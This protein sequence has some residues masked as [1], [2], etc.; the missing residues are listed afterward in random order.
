MNWEDRLSFNQDF[1]YATYQKG[2]DSV[3]IATARALCLSGLDILRINLIPLSEWKCCYRMLLPSP[4]EVRWRGGLQAVRDQIRRG[5]L[6]IEDKIRPWTGGFWK[7]LILSGALRVQSHT[8]WGRYQ[9]WEASHSSLVRDIEL[10]SVGKH[11]EMSTGKSGCRRLSRTPSMLLPALDEDIVAGLFSGARI[12]TSG[13]GNWLILPASE[14]IKSLLG[15]MTILFHPW[16]P[17]R[18]QERIAVAP[19]YGSLF[20]VRMPLESSQRITAIRKP[21]LG[22]LLPLMYWEAYFAKEGQPIPPSAG[23]LPYCISPR[24][25]RRRKYRRSDFHKMAVLKYGILSLA[26]PLRQAMLFWI[27][28]RS[29]TI[30]KVITPQAD[31]D[32]ISA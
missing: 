32:S 31:C 9:I 19:F 6:G 25:Y 2:E 30:D 28:S 7:G 5:G 20:A 10:A 24:T 21:A 13:D 8:S 12:E 29:T 4:G 14:E 26:P 18:N 15:R 17:F 23:I 27:R 16:K 11:F 1:R 22:E 3:L